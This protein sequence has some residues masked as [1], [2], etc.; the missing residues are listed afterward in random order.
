MVVCF[1]AYVS[2][3]FSLPLI[4]CTV[5]HHKVLPFIVF[6]YQLTVFLS[7]LSMLI[8]ICIMAVFYILE[9][10]KALEIFFWN[11][12]WHN[13][14]QTMAMVKLLPIMLIN[15]SGTS[16]HYWWK[17]LYYIVQILSGS[18]ILLCNCSHLM[19]DCRNWV[20]I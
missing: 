16:Y 7:S 3:I 1:Q 15:V 19:M 10:L 6:C 18:V 20:S 8:Y 14:L 17:S 12:R 4:T 13:M 11:Y 2:H 9:F 5:I